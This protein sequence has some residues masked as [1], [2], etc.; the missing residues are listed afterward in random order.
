MQQPAEEYM[1]NTEE[2][3]LMNQERVSKFVRRLYMV[4]S[5][6][7]YHD[8]VEW[9]ETGTAFKITDHTNFV[10]TIMPRYFGLTNWKSFHRQLN[11][12]RFAKINRM[13][14]EILEFEHTF[15]VRGQIAQLRR[16]RRITSRRYELEN[17][18]IQAQEAIDDAAR[19][20]LMGA[21]NERPGT[22]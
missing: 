19:D 15:F 20:S 7:Q 16:V 4:L 9:N 2:I 18:R 17:Q 8:I 10:N 1:E 12:Y 22:Q 5:N 14:K 6:R 21:T 3:D 11:F 13:N